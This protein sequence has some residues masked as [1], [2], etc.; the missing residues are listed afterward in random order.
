M[1][2]ELTKKKWACNSILALDVNPIIGAMN[3]YLT[4]KM[5]ERPKMGAVSDCCTLFS[6]TRVSSR[7]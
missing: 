1:A 5:V 6:M 7:L 4:I 3:A 2:T